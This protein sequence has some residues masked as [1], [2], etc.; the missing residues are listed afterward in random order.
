MEYEK[1]THDWSRDAEIEQMTTKL[2]QKLDLQPVKN[3]TSK[4]FKVVA[5]CLK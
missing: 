3:H 1:S 5:E 4:S 2:L